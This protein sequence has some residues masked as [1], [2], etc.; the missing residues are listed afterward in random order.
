MFPSLNDEPDLEPVNGL[1]GF[2]RG[3]PTDMDDPVI[4]VCPPSVLPVDMRAPECLGEVLTSLDR[5]DGALGLLMGRVSA[6]LVATDADTEDTSDRDREK[7][8]QSLS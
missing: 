8:V 1:D 6:Q 4:S 5:V 2:F 7:P 3:F